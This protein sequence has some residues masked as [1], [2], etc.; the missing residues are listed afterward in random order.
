LDISNQWCVFDEW[1]RA[2]GFNWRVVDALSLEDASSSVRA[3]IIGWASEVLTAWCC[4][5]A[6]VRLEAV[7]DALAFW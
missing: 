7:L 4:I 3:L 6:L 2:L 1:V 5:F